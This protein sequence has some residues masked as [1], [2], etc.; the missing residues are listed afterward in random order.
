M[1][2]R[3]DA[4]RAQPEDDAPARFA[5][6]LSGAAPTGGL[7]AVLGARAGGRGGGV[8]AI[9]LLRVLAAH[10]GRLIAPPGRPRPVV[11][12]VAD[13]TRAQPNLTALLALLLV[14]YGV[15]VLVH[16]LAGAPEAAA[17]A[18][19]ER[20]ERSGTDRA[21]RV[22]SAAVLRELGVLPAARLADAQA[23][24]DHRGIAYVPTAVLAPGLAR[25]LAQAPEAHAALQFLA[26]LLDPFGGDCY[27][28]ICAAHPDE[29]PR[30]RELVTATRADALLLRATEGEPFADPC[31]Q[32]QLE[33]FLAGMGTVCAESE[34]GSPGARPRLPAATDVAATAAWIARALAGEEPL[35]E[36]IVA[37]LGCCLNG[38][39]RTALAP[40]DPGP[41]QSRI[42]Q[43]GTS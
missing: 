3:D 31:R 14:R 18:A 37:Q 40:D 13:G 29:M 17:A 6:M 30:L 4:A 7:D 41:S 16:G 12:P 20:A 5:A 11:L 9:G 34:I 15:P 21:G 32:P 2:S 1:T 33:H 24:L 42:A 43:P 19:P 36:P 38:A 23:R 35:P 26:R 39:H 28:V 22:T 25:L 8:H 10:G 27:R